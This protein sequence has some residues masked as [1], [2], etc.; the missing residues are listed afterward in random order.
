MVEVAGQDRKINACLYRHDTPAANCLL[1]VR[2]HNHRGPRALRVSTDPL[3][4]SHGVDFPVFYISFRISKPLLFLIPLLSCRKFECELCDRSF[5]E[6]WALN[7]HMKLHSGE[8][9]YKCAWPF[10]HYSFLNLSAMKDHYRTHT[11]EAHTANCS[12]INVLSD[13]ANSANARLNSLGT[14]P[15]FPL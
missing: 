13:S 4:I 15:F 6:K 1:C 3:L 2:E 7:N 9:P 14:A 10:C 12:L 5:S 8:K 11:G